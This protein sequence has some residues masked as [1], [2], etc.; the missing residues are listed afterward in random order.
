M[1]MLLEILFVALA[2]LI[3]QPKLFA[4]IVFGLMIIIGL[5]YLSTVMARYG[6]NN[7]PLIVFIITFTPVI[8]LGVGCY[9]KASKK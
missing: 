4:K 5:I 2:L 8:L 6:E 1:E 3:I 9:A 7:Q